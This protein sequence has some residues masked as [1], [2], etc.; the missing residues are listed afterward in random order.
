L[1]GCPRKPD[2]WR[3]HQWFGWILPCNGDI[4]NRFSAISSTDLTK[5]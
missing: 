1:D 4:K 5:E 3:S 2:F